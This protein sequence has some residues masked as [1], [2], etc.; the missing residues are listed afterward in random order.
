MNF[1]S[2]AAGR[3][4][5]TLQIVVDH[6]PLVAADRPDVIP[7]DI[8]MPRLSGWKVAAALPADEKTD[9][10][11]TAKPSVDGNLPRRSGLVLGARRVAAP[12]R[13]ADGERALHALSLVSVDRAVDLVGAVLR[14]GDVERRALGFEELELFELPPQLA[15]TTTAGTSTSA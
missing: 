3:V 5:S 7:L 6:D 2:Y 9:Q 10:I 1:E 12:G 8:M 15:T 13:L 14:E 4:A 11:P